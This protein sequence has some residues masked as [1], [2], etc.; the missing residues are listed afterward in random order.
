MFYITNHVCIL[1]K[2][3][4]TCLFLSNMC[5]GV[6]SCKTSKQAGAREDKCHQRWK[7]VKLMYKVTIC[8]PSHLIGNTLNKQE[9]AVAA[10]FSASLNKFK[11]V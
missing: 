7:F 11:G 9:P 10:Q 1:L 3:N 8:Q 2:L 6:K 4:V 5:N